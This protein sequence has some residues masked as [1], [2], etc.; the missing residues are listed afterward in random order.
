MQQ[1]CI[2]RKNA[3]YIQQHL[4]LPA[5]TEL[6]VKGGYAS[7]VLIAVRYKLLLSREKAQ[8]V[9]KHLK[10]GRETFLIALLGQV[11]AF[12]I[13]SNSLLLLIDNLLQLLTLDKSGRNLS[14]G[15]KHS[16]LIL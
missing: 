4:L 9:I 12:L 10:V 2:A 11:Y 7:G 14:H 16:L 3:S 13:C 5:A 1:N 15:R 8:L 6:R